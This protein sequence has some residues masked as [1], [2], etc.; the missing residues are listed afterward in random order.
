V[1]E[2]GPA[3]AT[4][5]DE[6]ASLEYPPDRKNNNFIRN[7]IDLITFEQ[8]TLQPLDHFHTPM[9]ACLEATLKYDFF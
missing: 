9:P 1:R 7:I 8:L 3:P 6:C 5:A 2:E 4:M